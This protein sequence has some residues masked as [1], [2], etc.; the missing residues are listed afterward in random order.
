MHKFTSL[1]L[2]CLK[3]CILINCQ[4]RPS[5][6]QHFFCS[7]LVVMMMTV[8][9]VMIVMVIMMT[10]LIMMMLVIKAVLKDEVRPD[11]VRVDTDDDHAD[12]AGDQIQVTFIIY[13]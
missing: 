10:V 2:I 3:R 12:R 13:N 8:L 1:M 6:S 4:T 9:M 5:T 7:D 11:V